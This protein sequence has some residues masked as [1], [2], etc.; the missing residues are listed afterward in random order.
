MKSILLAAAALAAVAAS[1]L[2][3]T[4]EGGLPPGAGSE[5][6]SAKCSTCHSLG[7]VVSQHRSKAGWTDTVSMM[8]DKGLEVT[9]AEAEQ[10]ATYLAASFGPVPDTIT[11]AET[12]PPA[13]ATP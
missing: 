1:A 3:Q 11:P 12:A 2:A 7:R 9:P 5:L 8:M 6:A 10:I 4:P 13:V